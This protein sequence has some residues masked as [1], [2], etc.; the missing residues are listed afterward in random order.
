MG[1]YEQEII[2]ITAARFL[3]PGVLFIISVHKPLKP[4]KYLLE[5]REDDIEEPKEKEGVKNKRN[6]KEGRK[7]MK[8]CLLVSCFLFILFFLL[9]P[10]FQ[11]AFFLVRERS[12]RKKD[13]W[14]KRKKEDTMKIKKPTKTRSGQILCLLILSCLLSFYF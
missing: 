11:S 9:S 7:L 2:N 4:Q 14:K 3:F 13:D 5:R 1:A 10:F 6:K 12:V 8:M